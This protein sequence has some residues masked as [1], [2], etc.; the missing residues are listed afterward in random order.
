[1]EAGRR[2]RGSPVGAHRARRRLPLHGARGMGVLTLRAR[3]VLA[4]AYLLVLAIGSMLVPLVRSVRDRV[5]AEVETQALS[6]AETV[7]ATYAGGADADSL[8]ASA[9]R[10]VRGRVVIVDRRGRVIAD[11]S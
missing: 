2:R 6:Q 5:N 9:A 1:R 11:S 4:L 8:V 10:E 7:A 3:L